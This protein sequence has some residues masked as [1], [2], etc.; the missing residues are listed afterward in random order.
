MRLVKRF[1]KL[2]D[3]LNMY[4]DGKKIHIVMDSDSIQIKEDQ[5]SLMGE[6][7]TRFEDLD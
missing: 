2:V 4:K 5:I 7:A 3:V 1:G 6:S